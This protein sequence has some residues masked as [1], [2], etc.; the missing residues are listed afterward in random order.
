MLWAV[1]YAA[2]VIIFVVLA[3]IVSERWT[4][5]ILSFNALLGVV[6]IVHAFRLRKEYLLRLDLIKRETGNVSVTSQG[7]SRRTD[8]SEDSRFY[9]QTDS[10]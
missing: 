1:F 8:V 2:P 7:R 6:S 4:N 5:A 3:G 10:F 9:L